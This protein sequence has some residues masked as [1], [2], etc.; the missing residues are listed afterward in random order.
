MWI[1]LSG[2]CVA[3]AS[4]VRWVRPGKGHAG[5]NRAV[6]GYEVLVRVPL[7]LPARLLARMPESGCCSEVGQENE[8]EGMGKVADHAGAGFMGWIVTHPRQSRASWDAIIGR[9]AGA[10]RGEWERLPASPMVMLAGQRVRF[11][12]IDALA[13]VPT[14]RSI[15]PDWLI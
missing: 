2:G 15:A 1:G 3:R 11:A 8:Q 12:R 7:G 9:C 13:F 4:D 10:A 5:E 6:P 14:A